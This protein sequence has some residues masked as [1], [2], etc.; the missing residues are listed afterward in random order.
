M[1]TDIETKADKYRQ[2]DSQKKKHIQIDTNKET[3]KT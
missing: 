2:K 1:G 3:D